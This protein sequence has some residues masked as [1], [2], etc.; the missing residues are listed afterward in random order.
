MANTGVDG[1]MYNVAPT[2]VNSLLPPTLVNTVT[3]V[4]GANG[5]LVILT[6]TTILPPGSYL[7]GGSFSATATAGNAWANGDT[8]IFR[9][10]DTTGSLTN[11][12]QA[13]LTGYSQVGTGPYA[14]A[15]TVTGVITLTASGTLTWGVTVVEGSQTGKVFTLGNGYY[16]RIS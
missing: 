6:P 13:T 3:S 14:L 11:V 16:Q 5:S 10:Y 4:N 12:P 2:G 8:F 1:T 15:A 7:V 9:I